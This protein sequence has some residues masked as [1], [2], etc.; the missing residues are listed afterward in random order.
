MRSAL[1][2][3]TLPADWCVCLAFSMRIRP[4]PL[5]VGKGVLIRLKSV[6]NDRNFTWDIS[7]TWWIVHGN[8]S[9]IILV[10]RTLGGLYL[11][12]FTY[13]WI[14]L[15]LSFSAVPSSDSLIFALVYTPSCW[16]FLLIYSVLIRKMLAGSPGD[17]AVLPV[18]DGGGGTTWTIHLIWAVANI[19]HIAK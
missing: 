14:C 8:C 3:H 4:G 9:T 1:P 19:Y 7:H 18:I 2:A 15:F 5:E 10:L 17:Y 13:I 16:F 11:L 6:W 12:L